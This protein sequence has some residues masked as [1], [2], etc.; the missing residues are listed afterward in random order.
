MTFDEVVQRFE[1]KRVGLQW[2]ARCPCHADRVASLALKEGD[3]GW[4]LH[5][6]AGCTTAGILEAA[7]MRPQDLFYE[8]RQRPTNGNGHQQIQQIVATY[9][10]RDE[11]GAL[12]YQVIRFASKRF[13]QRRADGAW[14]I[15]GVRRVLYRLPEL[16]ATPLEQP[17]F[18]AEG[19][20][21]VDN[22]HARGVLATTNSGGA[23]AKWLPEYC[24]ALRGRPV[25]LLPDNDEPGRKHARD[26]TTWLDG[27]A[28]S[29]RVLE[30][31]GLPDKGDVSDWLAAGHT[32]EELLALSRRAPLGRDWLTAKAAHEPGRIVVV[33]L[34]DVEPEQITWLWSGRIPF[35][36]ITV[37]DGDPGLGKSTMMLDLAARLTTGRPFP[38]EQTGVGPGAVLFISHEDGIADTLRPRADAAGAN[39]TLI[40]AIKGTLEED[41]SLRLPTIPGDLAGLEKLIVEHKLRLVVIDPLYAYLDPGTNSYSDHNVRCALAP[42][43]TVAERTGA[44]V[45]LVRHL[46]K[47]GGASAMYR[48]GGSIGI[49]GIARSGLLLA[50]DPDDDATR[51]VACVKSNLGPPPAS[52]TWRFAGGTPPHIN[53]LGESRLCAD[54]L[55]NVQVDDEEGRSALDEAKSFLRDAL[56][57]GAV[58]M[59]EIVRQARAAGIAETTLRRAKQRLQVQARKQSFSGAWE[60]ELPKVVFSNNGAP[61][62]N[63]PAWSNPNHAISNGISCAPAKAIKEING[64]QEDQ[65]THLGHAQRSREPGEDD[66]DL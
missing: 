44:A 48:G 25:V 64:H 12:L 62:E 4:L 5:C 53:W 50:K 14:G 34:A 11:Q 13:L 54:S 16:M 8:Q 23:S 61:S 15:E 39:N 57:G 17:V 7:G 58:Q 52:L 30:L 19:E 41:G 59:K 21:D 35:G 51:I 45:V 6:H 22:L 26:A 3:R 32:V 31:P 18:I 66:D 43:A 40:Q 10:Y 65:L 24:E 63:W 37:L 20:K 29:V 28:A 46:R 47:S 42:L 38:G 60:W 2:M 36:K 49:I 9:D 56:T 33:C 1:A 55:V 27:N